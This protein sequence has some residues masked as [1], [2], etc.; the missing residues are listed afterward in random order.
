MTC[1]IRVL[2]REKCRMRFSLFYDWLPLKRQRTRCTFNFLFLHYRWIVCE[3]VVEFYT[4]AV[5]L[6]SDSWREEGDGVLKEGPENRQPVHGPVT[7]SAALHWDPEQIR[8]FLRKR[9]W[10]GMCTFFFPLVLLVCTT[11][12]S[13]HAFSEPG[14]HCE[15]LMSFQRTSSA[16]GH[17][18]LPGEMPSNLP[19][20]LSLL[21]QCWDLLGLQGDAHSLV[22]IYQTDTPSASGGSF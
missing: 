3:C 5:S 19:C 15:I 12:H 13:W 20:S 18:E 7:A 8:L 22:V 4:S 10:C 9:E 14:L 2:K 16:D 17:I 1:I 11:T 21:E 6:S